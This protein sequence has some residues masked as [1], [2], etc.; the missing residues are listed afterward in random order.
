MCGTIAVATPIHTAAAAQM[1]IHR[2]AVIDITTSR[3]FLFIF[4]H[5]RMVSKW[6][7]LDC[8]CKI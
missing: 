4:P 1:T 3:F 5:K 8:I 7:E 2:K 6:D